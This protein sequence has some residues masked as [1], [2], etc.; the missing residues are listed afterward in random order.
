MK[1]QVAELALALADLLE[2][3]LSRIST[4]EE[5]EFLCSRYGW[6]VSLDETAVGTISQGLKA[7]DAVQEFLTLAGPLRQKLAS[8]GAALTV[9]DV[10][11]VA[12]ALDTSIQAVIGFKA[13]AIGGLP[14]PLLSVKPCN[15]VGQSSSITTRQ[16][17]QQ[18]KDLVHLCSPCSRDVL[19]NRSTRD[20]GI[21]PSE[22]KSSIIGQDTVPNAA[23][24][25]KAAAPPERT[26]V[27]RMRRQVAVETIDDSIATIARFRIPVSLQDCPSAPSAAA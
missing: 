17:I 20:L 8:G 25:A 13:A 19:R 15:P 11:S 12:R 26:A 21:Q 10:A 3:L 5:L 27:D 1:G 2:P 23:G 4:P 14:P 22:S 7:R 18:T 9:E 6:R 16:L 24:A